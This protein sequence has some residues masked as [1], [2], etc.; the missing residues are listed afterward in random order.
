MKLNTSFSLLLFFSLIIGPAMAQ[1]VVPTKAVEFEKLKAQNHF[2]QK[3]AAQT[4]EYDVHYYE[5]NLNLIPTSRFIQ[6]SVKIHFISTINSMDSIVV[7]FGNQLIADS[8]I[9]N[10]ISYSNVNT[11]GN[12][13]ISFDFP[14]SLGIGAQDSIEIFYRGTH[15]GGSSSPPFARVNIPNGNLIWTLSEPYGAQEW[16]PCK[17]DLTDKADSVAINVTVPLGNKVVS[18]GLLL[19]IDTVGTNETHHWKTTYPTV[20]YLVAIGAGT[21]D[22]YEEKYALNNDSLLMHH[23]LYSNQTHA[24]SSN[25][26]LPMLQLFDSLFGTYPFIKEKYGHASFSFG[27]GMEHQTVS[28]MGSYGGELKA[29]ELAHQWFGNKVTCGSWS[30]LWLNESFATYLTGLTYNFNVVH[31]S[32]YWPAWLNGTEQGGLAFPH[33][34]VYRY[35]NDTLYVNTLFNGQVYAKGAI[36]LHTLR[37]KIGDSAFFA[38]VKNYITDPNLEFGFAK[39]PDLIQ[40]LEASYGSSLTEFFKDWIYGAGYPRISS[41]WSQNGSNFQLTVQQTPSDTSVSFFEIPVPYRLIGPNID[42]IIVVDPTT[43]TETFNLNINQIVTA[44][45][46]DPNKDIFAE[47]LLTTAIDNNNLSD[48]RFNVFPNPSKEFIN[49]Y[50]SEDLKVQE[51]KI[52]S[53]RGKLIASPKV[54]QLINISGLSNGF[55]ILVLETNRG[56]LKSKFQKID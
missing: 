40:H 35:G 42:T 49:L 6:G 3:S 5:I 18:N 16:W 25:G 56:R 4:V 48:N 11:S 7:D 9:H 30:D 44:I 38:G 28:F 33:G 23:F 51:I 31:N 29:H 12:N 19:S 20:A 53:V 52:Y 14:G 47:E 32:L 41:Y 17:N 26:I 15:R 55:Y 39:T 43:N 45:E 24:N 27:G 34:S 13:T 22:F 36:T 10:Q 37:W 50:T 54:E 21:Y 8:I 46:F 1:F 2:N